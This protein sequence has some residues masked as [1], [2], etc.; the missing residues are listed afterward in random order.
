M[1]TVQERLAKDGRDLSPASRLCQSHPR[2]A[3]T[4][5]EGIDIT[6]SPSEVF[7]SREAPI[8]ATN[9]PKQVLLPR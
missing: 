3:L 5:I 7:I 8:K 1:T 9:Q 4:H 2:Y 6:D